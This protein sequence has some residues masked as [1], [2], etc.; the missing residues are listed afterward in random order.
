MRS[1]AVVTSILLALACAGLSLNAGAAEDKPG[2]FKYVG[3]RSCRSCHSSKA[4]G[5]IEFRI[6]EKSPHAGAW[7]TLKSEEAK[8]VAAGLGIDKPEESPA[9]LSCHSTAYGVDKKLKDENTHPSHGVTCEACHG[10]GSAYK[11]F[12]VMKNPDLAKKLGLE[13]RP[14]EELCKQCHNDKSPTFKGFNFKEASAK[15]YHGK[16]SQN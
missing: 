12:K 13:P 10:P 9:C 3:K 16:K 1:K 6:W 7:Q 5:G 4:V 8:K 15:I 2:E 14:G 11:E